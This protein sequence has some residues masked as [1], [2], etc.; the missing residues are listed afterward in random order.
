MIELE[1]ERELAN[2]VIIAKFLKLFFFFYLIKKKIWK[3]SEIRV[4]V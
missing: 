4:R 3:P 2:L 1:D